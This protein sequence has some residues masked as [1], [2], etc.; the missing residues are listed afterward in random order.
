MNEDAAQSGAARAAPEPLRIQLLGDGAL[1]QAIFAAAQAEGFVVTRSEDA[2]VP[3]S[4]QLVIWARET[5]DVAELLEHARGWAAAGMPFV[6]AVSVPEGIHL[7]PLTVPGLNACIGCAAPPPATPLTTAPARLV[8]SAAQELVAGIERASRA[9]PAPPELVTSLV[10]LASDGSRQQH[11]L[12]PRQ[13]CSICG[14]AGSQASPFEPAAA[15]AVASVDPLADGIDVG[16]C[17]EHGAPLRRIGVIGGGTAGYLTALAIRKRR[18]EL[19]VTLIESSLRPVV[20]VGEATTPEMV[21]FVLDTLGVDELEL[22]REVR[23]T[24]KLGIRFEWGRSDRPHFHHPFSGPFLLDAVARDDDPELQSLGTQLMERELAPVLQLADGRTSPLLDSVPY[25]WHLDNPRLVNFLQRLAERR[26]IERIDALIEQVDRA[27]GGGV[28]GLT[29]DDGRRFEFDLYVDATGFRSLLLGDAL[30]AEFIDY[31][32][33]LFNDAAVVGEIELPGT[34]P[35][36]TLAETMDA[37][38]CWGIPTPEANHR[39]YV[40]STAFIDPD[41]AADEMRRKN[42]GLGDTRLIRFRSGRRSHCWQHNVVAVGN[43]Y[44]FVEPLESTALYMLVDQIEHLLGALPERGSPGAAVDDLNASIADHWDHLRG[45]LALHFRFNGRLD[46][47]YWRACRA[48][49]DL[50]RGEAL[51]EAFRHGAPLTAR[52]DRDRL[53]SRLLGNHFFGLLGVDNVLFGQGLETR[54]LQPTA[55]AGRYLRWRDRA[56]PALLDRALAHREA[57]AAYERWLQ[58]QQGR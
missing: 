14:G 45:F 56:R 24:W 33:T 2:L 42:P 54:V 16:E 9:P 34:I 31:R 44:G 18:P 20:G 11:R 29:S 6:A 36:F 3:G 17:P 21:A 5:G 38:W 4:A 28:A 27:D 13:G 23:P 32:G 47:E 10:S 53:R 7:G 12:R 43:A 40:F 48:D 22:Y 8:A 30:G 39:G 25:A 51:V 58:V 50:A 19:E 37:G 55:D 41:A 57:L 49:V 52:P 35:P 1:A 26:G 46:T 15:L